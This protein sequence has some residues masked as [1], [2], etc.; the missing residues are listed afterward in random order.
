M[1]MPVSCPFQFISQADKS[2]KKYTLFDKGGV[3][4]VVFE[5]REAGASASGCTR[6][7][8]DGFGEES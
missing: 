4:I 3:P 1:A 5:A 8:L 7:S 2:V 6:L